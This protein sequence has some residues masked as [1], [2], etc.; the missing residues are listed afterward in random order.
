[1]K[2]QPA[3]SS[4][5]MEGPG[6]FGFCPILPRIHDRFT[7]RELTET[8]RTPAAT[9]SRAHPCGSKKKKKKLKIIK[10]HPGKA[11]LGELCAATVQSKELNDPY[12]KK[13]FSPPFPAGRRIS[14]AT[15]PAPWHESHQP[16]LIVAFQL[17]QVTSNF[18]PLYHPARR[19]AQ[20]CT[21]V[22]EGISGFLPNK[23]CQ[24]QLES[25]RTLEKQRCEGRTKPSW[26]ITRQPPSKRS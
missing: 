5:R 7:Q 15:E 17:S 11:V 20:H 9:C 26:L 4:R 19:S 14:L 6:A 25:F 16:G 8:L 23:P 10:K 2:S 3:Y 18:F 1:M 13:V 12:K 22:S 24:A 21:Q